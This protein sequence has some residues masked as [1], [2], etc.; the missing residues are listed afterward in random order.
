MVVGLTRRELGRAAG[1]SE[2]G[3]GEKH[4][5]DAAEGGVQTRCLVTLADRHLAKTPLSAVR[6]LAILASMKS[7]A[8]PTFEGL[9]PSSERAS[10]AARA[11]SVKVG[12]R[13][14]LALRRAL[15]RRGLRYRLHDADLPGHP[16]IVFPK[17]RVAVFC[18]GDFW[19]GRDFDA[20]VAKLERGHNAAYWIAKVCKNIERDIRHTRALEMAGWVVLRFWETDLLRQAGEIADRIAIILAHQPP[21]D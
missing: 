2:G 17:H 9:T 7:R 15:W 5:L 16:D 21:T 12:T 11:A 3:G 18:D 10:A 19:H 20:R 13:C 8:T 4:I 6:C 1:G 14:E